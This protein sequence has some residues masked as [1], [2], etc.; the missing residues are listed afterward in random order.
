M[1]MLN[2]RFILIRNVHNER[3]AVI[4]DQLF[5]VHLLVLEDADSVSC[6]IIRQNADEV[7]ELLTA[8]RRE[9]QQRILKNSF[10][11]HRHIVIERRTA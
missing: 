5:L 11:R 7:D 2:I 8:A 4:V 6:F 1:N 10:Q 9:M 3:N